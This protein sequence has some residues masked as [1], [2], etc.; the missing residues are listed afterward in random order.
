M[1][2]FARD[3]AVGAAAAVPRGA[4][5]GERALRAEREG[6]LPREV[7][8]ECVP[9]RHGGV[10]RGAELCGRERPRQVRVVRRQLCLVRTV[11]FVV[12][13]VLICAPR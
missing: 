5:H 13:L 8:E 1:P 12:R 11:S 7:A 6:R 4:H 10:L 2:L 3:H 9:L